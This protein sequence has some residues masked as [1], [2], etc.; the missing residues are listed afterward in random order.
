M[1]RGDEAH[2]SH[3]EPSHHSPQR[4]VTGY[5]IRVHAALLPCGELVLQD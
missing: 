4:T 1:L 5:E 3:A 2:K